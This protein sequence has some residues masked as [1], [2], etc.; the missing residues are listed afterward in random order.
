MSCC[1][2]TGQILPKLTAQR[3]RLSSIG[4]ETFTPI[5]DVP[6]AVGTVDM[7]NGHNC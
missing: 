3:E 6:A 7:F 5:G 4:V 1:P 2:Y